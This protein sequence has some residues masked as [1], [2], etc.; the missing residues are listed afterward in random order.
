MELE[1]Q[2]TCGEDGVRAAEERRHRVFARLGVRHMD[3]LVES[4]LASLALDFACFDVQVLADMWFGVEV[5]T[6]LD[7]Q[8]LWVPCDDPADGFLAIWEELAGRHPERVS[9]DPAHSDGRI[10]VATRISEVL[11][12]QYLEAEHAYGTHRKAAHRDDN[13]CPPCEDCDVHRALR[14]RALVSLE[15]EWGSRVLDPAA[16]KAWG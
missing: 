8:C 1:M 12:R 11:L 4:V 13:D 10:R 5:V 15:H 2:C 6:K 3:E 7:P 14:A 9:Q 16:E